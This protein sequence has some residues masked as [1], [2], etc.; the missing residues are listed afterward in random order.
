M[1]LGITL[2][3]MKNKLID[4]ALM[5]GSRSVHGWILSKVKQ[6]FQ[7]DNNFFFQD[8]IV[9]IRPAT[10]HMEALCIRSNKIVV[11]PTDFQP[12]FINKEHH[13][14]HMAQSL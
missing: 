8:D 13:L 10:H 12:R 6:T 14:Y 3:D 4:T 2:L 9:I 1:F 11:M 7:H 5:N